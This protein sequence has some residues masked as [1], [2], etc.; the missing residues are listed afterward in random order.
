MSVI[1]STILGAITSVLPEALRIWGRKQELDHER[2][3]FDLRIKEFA[4]KSEYQMG[5]EEVRA[6]AIEGKSLRDHDS[7]LDGGYFINRLRASVRPVITY[8]FFGT[9]LFVKAVG[10]Y[11]IFQGNSNDYISLAYA[12]DSIYGVIWGPDEQA[13][14]GAII[15]FWFGSRA[16]EKFRNITN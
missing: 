14:F 9:F 6:D 10:I 2:A 16:I 15:G 11:L 13:L 7:K 3:L 8:L 12:W 4:A 1:V 5:V